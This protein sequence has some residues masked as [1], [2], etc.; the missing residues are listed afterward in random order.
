M[1]LNKKLSIKWQSIIKVNEFQIFTY[2]WYVLDGKI[3][4]N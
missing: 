3:K 2:K 4:A 1:R